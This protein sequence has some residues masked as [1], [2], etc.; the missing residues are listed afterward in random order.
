MRRKKE[1][2][3]NQAQRFSIRKFSFGVTSVLLGTVFLANTAMADEVSGISNDSQPKTADTRD[4]E[5]I[6]PA[7][8]IQPTQ[9]VN[10]PAAN[11]VQPVQSTQ[12]AAQPE[13][14]QPTEKVEKTV[15]VKKDQLTEL[16]S[17]LLTLLGNINRDKVSK[18]SLLEYESVLS[19][20]QE[21][22]QNESATQLEVDAQVR[23]VRSAI[24][25]AKSF[26]KVK[27]TTEE[28]I[29]PKI[30]NDETVVTP[31]TETEI[32]HS[33][34][35][36]KEDLQKYVKKSEVTT[37]KPNV[38]AAEEILE[39]ISKQL[40]NTTL[41]SKELTTLLEQAKAVRN[42]LVNE[43]LRATS[44]SH[45][46]RNNRSMGEGAGFRAT[47]TDEGRVEG[48][49]INVKE[50]ISEEKFGGGGVSDGQRTRTIDKTFMTAKYS[51]EDGKKYITYDVYFQNDGK[52]LSGTTGNAFWFYPPRDLLYSG[53]SYPVGVVSDVYY[54]RYQNNAGTGRLS[55]NPNNFTRVGDRYTV[56]L[57][58]L[59]SNSY[60]D[61]G[62]QALWSAAGG[63][64]Q[65]S[66][67][68]TR[69][70]QRQQMLKS[71][72]DNEEL[73]RIIKNPDGSYPVASYSHIL[74]VSPKQNYA[75]K[76]HIKVRLKD[77]VTDAQAQKAGTMAVTAKEGKA[78]NALQAYV[79]AAT[80]TKLESR[81]DKQLYPIKGK[82]VTKNSRGFS[83]RCK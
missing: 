4:G 7:Q 58:R 74:T 43:E 67:G 46:L 8:P 41:T 62:S 81:P 49:L 73:N 80:G 76:F 30:G 21:V 15:E 39:N 42:S 47:T 28:N 37:D 38:T 19:K 77:N 75:Y 12:P 59:A 83:W 71:L 9:P 45:D 35:T 40:E 63:L 27:S 54:E 56:P 78:F 6:N 65:M 36:V 29:A 22:L 50:Y 31:K 18:T 1:N 60:Q 48:A 66:G 79:Y 55:D 61:S 51:Q 5:L 64:F 11:V 25:I 3:W 52:A 20:A 23:K 82:E 26:P 32:K 70:D 2:M 17:D 16:V 13:L 53:G 57:G 33:L 69:D 14:D 44:G 24:S 68:P 72:K 34:E 10:Q